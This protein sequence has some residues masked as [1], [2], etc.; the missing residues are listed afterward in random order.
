MTLSTPTRPAFSSQAERELFAQLQEKLRQVRLDEKLYHLAEGD[1][2]LD[3]EQL[4]EYTKQRVAAQRAENLGI[5]DSLEGG[6]VL[7]GILQDGKIVRWTAG[8]VLTYCVRSATFASPADYKVAVD[9]MARATRDWEATCGVTFEHRQELDTA[10]A[11]SVVFTVRGIAEQGG[12][13]A[14]AFFPNDPPERRQLVITPSFFSASLR[15]DRAGVLRHELGHVLGFRHEHIRSGAPPVCRGE[16]VDD[17]ID[18]TA[19]DPRSVMHYFCGG[20]GTSELAITKLDQE[21]ARR[22]YGP[23]L[24][25]T[26]FVK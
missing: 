24:A 22:V 23:P 21:G 3:A 4:V 2:L 14:A 26:V 1:L 25:Q 20:V 16:S 10:S 18:L 19:Y 11:P 17:T 9:A 12:L 15:F 8:H 7:L 5:D 13:I 6:R